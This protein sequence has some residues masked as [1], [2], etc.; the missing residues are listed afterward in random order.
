MTWEWPEG[1]RDSLI[2]LY[3]P[4]VDRVADP[5]GIGPAQWKSFRDR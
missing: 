5:Y 3:T 1:M 2:S 4:Q